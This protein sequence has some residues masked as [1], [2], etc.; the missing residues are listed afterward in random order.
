MSSNTRS[1]FD[2]LRSRRLA[3][4]FAALIAVSLAIVGGSY[5]AH[6]VH[7]QDKA[8]NSSD[9]TPLKI[10]T[11]SVAPNQFA[12][13]AKQVGPAVVNINT[14]TLPKQSANPRSRV[15]PHRNV[16]QPQQPDGDDQD[17][18]GSGQAV[19]QGPDSPG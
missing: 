13:I 17:G 11:G 10:P 14:R 9:A 3:T 16:P 18:D 4:T 6:G 5:A 2:R 15:N 19:P 7:G 8:D 12:Q 1:L